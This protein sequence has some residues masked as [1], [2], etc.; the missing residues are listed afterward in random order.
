M[1]D[2]ARILIITCQPA[3]SWGANLARWM[4]GVARCFQGTRIAGRDGGIAHRIS[5]EIIEPVREAVGD[6]IS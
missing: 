3:R 5:E 4:S 6:T 2:L 1:S